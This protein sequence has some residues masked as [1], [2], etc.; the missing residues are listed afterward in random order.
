MNQPKLSLK[1]SLPP[2]FAVL[3]GLMLVSVGPACVGV[4][5]AAAQALSDAELSAA[6]QKATTLTEQDRQKVLELLGSTEQKTEEAVAKKPAQATPQGINDAVQPKTLGGTPATKV[7][8]TNPAPK[9]APETP[10]SKYPLFGSA[11]FKLAPSTFEP[12][13]YGPVPDDYTIGPGDELI[14]ELWGEVTSRNSYTVDRRGTILLKDAGQLSVVGENLQSAKRNIIRRLS[15]VY[16]GVKPDGGGTTHV[17]VSLG[18]LR[19]IRIFII[20]EARRPG[21]YEVSSVSTVSQALYAAGGPSPIGSMRDIQLVRN[22]QVVAHLDLYRYLLEGKREGDLILKEGDTIFLPAAGKIVA[23]TGPVRRHRRFELTEDEGLRHAL[24]YAGGLA[25]EARADIAVISRILPPQQ[26]RDGDVDR[27]DLDAPLD[28]YFDENAPMIEL[29]DGDIVRVLRI[30]PRAERYV[31]VT[32]S[33]VLPGRYGWQEGMR[34]TDLL[35]KAK[36]P[37]RDALLQRAL[38][39]RVKDDYTRE[40]FPIN[41]VEAATDSTADLELAPMDSLVVFSRRILE[42]EHRVTILGQVR[43]PGEFVW[44]DGMTLRD[45]ILEAGGTLEG[46]EMNQAEVS[47]LDPPQGENDDRLANIITVSLAGEIGQGDADRFLLQNHDNV[48][49]RLIPGWELQRNVVVRGEVKYPG[50]Y[51]LLTR[52]ERLSSV[53]ERAGGLLDTAFPKGFRLLRT[54][55]NAGNVGLDLAD[56]LENKGGPNDIVLEAGDE[57]IVPQLQ[58]SVKVTGEVNFPTSVIYQKGKSIGDYVD[59]AGGYTSQADKGRTHVVYPNGLSAKVKK[60]WWDPH[61]ETGSTIIVPRKAPGQGIDWGKVIIGTTSV[62]ASLA[63]IYL[64]IW[65]TQN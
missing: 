52:D 27:V 24:R 14:V 16:S 34:L 59:R 23:V 46:A 41:L 30:N 28:G 4:S 33:V 1:S 13:S 25:P 39:V 38:L 43:R 36:G 6:R 55:D 20:G 8:T 5:T 56:A 57:I 60:F 47:R 17:D 37:W 63:T 44:Y 49:I 42:A 61:V 9:A 19:S 64:V 31:S 45:L 7:A 10:P 26:R 21:G 32:G 22:N 53:I 62:V 2:L 48:F 50:V 12:A 65:T 51:T 29:E 40:S 58:M 11:L 54:K 3:L 35:K 15:T 18:R